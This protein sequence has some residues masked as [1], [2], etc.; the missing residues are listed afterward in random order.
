MSSVKLF[1]L[2][3]LIFSFVSVQAQRDKPYSPLRIYHVEVPGTL[4]EVLDVEDLKTE[5]RIFYRIN[6]GNPYADYTWYH[7]SFDNIKIT[8][9]INCHDL[10]F[11][12]KCDRMKVEGA[13]W[14]TDF[15][16]K[17]DLSEASIV[18]NDEPYRWSLADR[19]P[20][21]NYVNNSRVPRS[22]PED[23]RIG[24]YA[25]Y[26]CT[27]DK[28]IFPNN[29]KSLHEYAFDDGCRID[30][31]VFGDSLEDFPLMNDT[32]VTME[33]C[34]NN[35]YDLVSDFHAEIM[36]RFSYHSYI[37]ISDKNPN[38][39]SVNGSLYD[40]E[41]TTLL[42]CYMNGIIKN[43]FPKTMRHIG[44]GVRLSTD[45]SLIDFPEELVSIGHWGIGLVT[46]WNYVG[47]DERFTWVP[48]PLAGKDY[49]YTFFLTESL[50]YIGEYGLKNCQNTNII[51]G[52]NVKQIG[53]RAFYNWESY[54][55]GRGN[56]VL[57]CLSSTPPEV[58][59][60]A[61]LGEIDYQEYYKHKCVVVP[62]GSKAAY[63]KV[64]GIANHFEEIVEV[65]DVMAYYHEQLPVGIEERENSVLS[66]QEIGRYNLQ[67]VRLKEPM[68]GVNIIKYSD[69]S[70]KKVWVK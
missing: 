50:E 18:G 9:R 63:E 14:S 39:T 66:S 52:E 40:K 16:G 37:E 13:G 10:L 59:N 64:P 46:G 68:P 62:M 49:I 25:L 2:A 31:L 53:Y 24:A 3:L 27:I 28:F 38:F 12:T 65:D 67:G 7:S 41:V 19:D 57:Y 55:N 35:L 5:Y 22:S 29:L 54:H 4:H 1:S 43:G 6:H 60:E 47:L 58:E 44:N 21:L 15:L 61:F 34:L 8:G 70:S 23:D 17:I 56:E 26:G 32:V 33:T 69:G 51:L 36:S 30:T 11:L 45:Y 48:T 42:R 20:G